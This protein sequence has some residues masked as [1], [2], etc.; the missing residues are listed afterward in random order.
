MFVGY[1]STYNWGELTHLLSGMS[2]QVYTTN[3]HKHPLKLLYVSTILQL[4]TM[5]LSILQLWYPLVI[6]YIAIEHGPVEIVDLPIKNGDFPLCSM[7]GIFTYIYPKNHPNVGKY[8]IHG[9]SFHSYVN[10]Y[11]TV[12][13]S[14]LIHP[15]LKTC[16]P[17][18]PAAPG[19]TRST[20][21]TP[22]DH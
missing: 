16:D 13:G 11:Q 2:H 17:P 19:S 1:S 22:L 20:R 6:C 5:P 7:Y 18:A 3:I 15:H 8:S 10:V 4:Q 21:V 14:G 9:G 12:H